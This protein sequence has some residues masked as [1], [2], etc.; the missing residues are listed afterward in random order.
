MN[1]R[2]SIGP[3]NCD[4]LRTLLRLTQQGHRPGVRARFGDADER[5]EDV[6]CIGGLAGGDATSED[7]PEEL[8]TG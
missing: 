2:F 7:A 6:D 3:N 5:S 4:I 8:E 1:E